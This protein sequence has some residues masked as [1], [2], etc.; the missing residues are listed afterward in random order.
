MNRHGSPESVA[1]WFKK[2]RPA[3]AKAIR[4]TIAADSANEAVVVSQIKADLAG[5]ELAKAY[6]VETQEVLNIGAVGID[7]WARSILAGILAP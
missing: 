4:E 7:Y 2:N 6:I 5:G 1:A 3:E